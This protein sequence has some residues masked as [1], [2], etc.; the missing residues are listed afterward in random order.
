MSSAVLPSAKVR[1]S[2]A[3]ILAEAQ[4]MF[5]ARGY[6]EVGLRDIAAGAGVSVALVQKRFGTKADLFEAALRDAQRLDPLLEC[7]K[8]DFGRHAVGQMVAPPAR[9]PMAILIRAAAHPETATIATRLLNEE[10]IARL[11]QWLEDGEA[12][13]RSIIVTMMCSGFM[14]YRHMLPLTTQG[15][16]ESQKIAEQMADMLQHIVSAR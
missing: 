12:R 6:A 1:P 4:R 8:D 15:P 11:S 14:M 3:A 10:V 5:S 13:K 16:E 2:E 7:H 9:H